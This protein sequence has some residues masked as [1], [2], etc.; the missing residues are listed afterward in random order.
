MDEKTSEYR[1]LFN[2]LTHSSLLILATLAVGLGLWLV[3]YFRN[4]DGLVSATA[5]DQAQLAR[6]FSIGAGFTTGV[7]TP[8]SLSVTSRIINPPD[9]Y[10]SPANIFF[11]AW[12]F[13]MFG[14]SDEVVLAANL[15]L[16]FLAG[17]AL[18][19]FS[20]RALGNLIWSSLTFI[21]F[22]SGL[23]VL[24]YAFSPSP[25][26]LLSLLLL[27]FVALFYR[28][29][30]RSLR[31]TF[32]LGL[33]A[34]LLYLAEF[35]YLLLALPAGLMTAGLYQG[36]K[37]KAALAFTAGF[38]LASSPWLIR[39]LAVAG[40]PF[41]SLRWFDFR[42]YTSAFPGN[43]FIRD[44][45]AAVRVASFPLSVFWTK[46]MG[47]ARLTSNYWLSFSHFLIMPFFLSSLFF[48]F[49]DRRWMRT[50]RMILLL[51]FSQLVMIC[52]GD[53]SLER[54][55]AFA[56]LIVL[57]G[58]F[59]F[60]DLLER[61]FPRPAVI[62][63]LCPAAFLLFSVYP[64]GLALFFGLPGHRYVSTLFTREEVKILKIIKIQDLFNRSMKIIIGID[65]S[66]MV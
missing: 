30:R 62:R 47:L 59:A 35:D 33:L 15:F 39:N 14:I 12:F 21:I 64:G 28:Y 11:L 29:D 48:N 44:Y 2:H 54:L 45:G 16:S 34:G 17:I 52:A 49:R 37:L 8:L 60:K 56:P 20:R 13:K 25:A 61:Y 55:L 53:G 41:F 66:Q 58:T 51:F 24:E 9:L 42:L 26:A 65:Q 23:G 19:I 36:K 32:L 1:D 63:R 18:F 4:Y 10:N 50:N 46:F 43:R 31:Q 38:L 27:A 40:N 5:I 6:R 57:S 3:Y 7:S 22:A